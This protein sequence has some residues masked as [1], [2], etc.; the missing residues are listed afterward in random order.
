MD[1]TPW[2]PKP[3]ITVLI[4]I[5]SACYVFYYAQRKFLGHHAIN[6]LPCLDRAHPP[7]GGAGRKYFHQRE[8]E[9]VNLRLESF[10][11]SLLCF[12]DICRRIYRAGFNV[13]RA[14]NQG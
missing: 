10:T 11:D 6:P 13:D 3:A 14:V 4:S 5:F 2:P 7:I 1:I 8:T 12:P 9:T